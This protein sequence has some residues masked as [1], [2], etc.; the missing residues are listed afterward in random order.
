MNKEINMTGFQKAAI[1]FGVVSAVLLAVTIYLGNG[2][3]NEA[4][5]R[6]NKYN[7]FDTTIVYKNG[8]WDTT[9]VKRQ[10]PTWLR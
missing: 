9:I 2:M 7:G 4:R 5:T 6:V 3:L 1:T 8:K 10:L